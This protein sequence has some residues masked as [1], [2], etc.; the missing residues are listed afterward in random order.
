M[1][2]VHVR[3]GDELS[4]WWSAVSSVTSSDDGRRVLTGVYVECGDVWSPVFGNF[5]G[6]TLTATDS[7]R[8]VTVGVPLAGGFSSD[9]GPAWN[10]ESGRV[11]VPGKA[12]K[13]P[14]RGA[15]SL[16]W[17]DDGADELDSV[18]VSLDVSK[19]GTSSVTTVSSIGG[20]FP[21]YRNLMPADRE[22]GRCEPVAVNPVY[23]GQMLSAFGKAGGADR[24]VRYVA[25]VSDMKP[26]RW[27]MM[28]PDN[29]YAA[30]AILMPVRVPEGNGSLG[31]PLG[32]LP[33]MA[34]K[35]SEAVAS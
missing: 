9:D 16:S 24:P 35:D 8:L 28:G 2:S 6:V 22:L 31:G 5:V 1:G 19:A 4:R 34:R 33:M 29:G 26:G 23:L 18:D 20:Y 21:K 15:L 30:S 17:N 10:G 11:L 32:H 14:A 12:V 7:Y 27:D 25:Q 13:I 3:F